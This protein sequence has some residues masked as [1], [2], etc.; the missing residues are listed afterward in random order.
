MRYI[1]DRN[2][3]PSLSVLVLALGLLVTLGVWRTIRNHERSEVDWLTE[4][5]A[6][7][8]RSD[9]ATDMEWQRYGLDRLA[10]LWEAADRDPPEDLWIRNAQ[11]Y[12][13][14]R[15]GSV[16]VEWLAPDG[17]RRV[18]ITKSGNPNIP[19]AFDGVPK[20]LLAQI[21]GSNA[22]MFS[23]PT[24][25]AHGDRQWAIAHPVYVKGQSRGC[26]VSFFDL[27]ESWDYILDDLKSLGFSFAVL[28]PNG[29]EYLLPESTESERELGKIV[30]V[31]LP[32][33]TWQ[34]RVWPKSSVVNV[35]KS[36]LAD[37][38]LA[39]GSTLTLLLV[40]TLHFAFRARRSSAR[41]HEA[42]DAL[43]R[44][45]ST[46]EGA[47][48]EL[49]RAHGQLE[50]RIEQ[51]TAALASSN[52]LLQKEV[53]DRQRAEQLLQELT[54]R[55]FQLQDEERRRLARELHDG[56]VQNLVAMAMDMGLVRD[57]VPPEDVGTKELVHECVRLI[58]R[59]TNELRTIS[60]L[61]HPPYFDELGLAA[62]LRDYCEGF[63][64]RSGIRITLNVDPELGRLGHDVEL[65]IFRVVQEALSNV[66]RHAHSPTA[67]ITLARDAGFVRLEV[68]DAGR[69]IPPE[70][71]DP[72]RG[73]LAGVGIAGMYERVRLLGGRLDIQ[74]GPTGTA[75][76]AVLPL[77]L[78]NFAAK[79]A[80]VSAGLVV[81]NSSSDAA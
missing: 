75:I 15:P 45:I 38:T 47:Q 20:A 50:M 33:V 17:E 25:V 11:L 41:I 52:T 70:I 77:S 42:N 30:D 37:V 73:S 79:S 48:E 81:G 4:L 80:V 34:I 22:A 43:Q 57:A 14:H 2:G 53:T 9:I 68:A 44:E 64:S 35:I 63:A 39:M 12:L 54:G 71:L 19:L 69:G 26:I 13:Q 29:S 32:G 60:Y 59:S 7:V 40:L 18:L 3:G 46:R 5:A 74:S 51:R 55:L 31:P 65:T 23:E 10:L 67:K 16:A 27:K 24:L 6:Q 62:A 72:N 76:R 66:H 49:R 61:L 58:E 1:T 28:I 78:P 56:V 8:V 21:R 36:R